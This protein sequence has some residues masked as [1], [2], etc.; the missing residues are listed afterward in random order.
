MTN[1]QKIKLVTGH[2]LPTPGPHFHSTP[3]QLVPVVMPVLLPGNISS[4]LA[5]DHLQI[6]LHGL[7][8][9]TRLSQNLYVFCQVGT[10]VPSFEILEWFVW[11]LILLS[12]VWWCISCFSFMSLI[13]DDTLPKSSPFGCFLPH[14]S[15]PEDPHEVLCSIN[16]DG[17]CLFKSTRKGSPLVGNR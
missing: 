9:I 14:E 4:Q 15:C 7:L 5:V 17:S 6:I 11:S 3:P 2:S 8:L 16:N 1:D 13:L 12:L 10:N